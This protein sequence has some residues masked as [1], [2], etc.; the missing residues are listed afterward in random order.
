MSKNFRPGIAPAILAGN[1]RELKNFYEN[2][3]SHFGEALAL[4]AE[5]TQAGR[6]IVYASDQDFRATT[7]VDFL[8]P[9]LGLST[10]HVPDDSWCATPP[11]WLLYD[12][13][14]LGQDRVDIRYVGADC[15]F[16][17]ERRGSWTGWG[18]S[19]LDL[20]VARR[21]P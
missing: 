21:V 20:A 12:P 17:F 5:E 16:R 8:A 19:D 2:R 1:A 9:A 7:M 11:D 14:R 15:Q 4:M 3:R 10:T 13:L 6:P 18:L